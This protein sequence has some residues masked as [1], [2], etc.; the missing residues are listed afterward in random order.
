MISQLDY[1]DHFAARRVAHR[2][3]ISECNSRCLKSVSA[4]ND[5]LQ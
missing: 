5:A 2:S 4:S 1:C 3:Y